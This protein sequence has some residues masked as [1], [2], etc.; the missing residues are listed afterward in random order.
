M[1]FS[2]EPSN[3]KVRSLDLDF[4]ELSWEM[5]DQTVDIWDY[6]FQIFRSESGEG[7]FDPISIA[8]EDRYVFVD[9]FLQIGHKWRVLFYRIRITHKPTGE[10]KDF[11]PYSALPEP[12]LI[13]MEVRRHINLLMQEFGGRRLWVLPLRTFGQRCDCWSHTLSRRTRSGCIKCYDTGFVRGYMAPIEIWGQIDPAPK[14]DQT[15]NVG[16]TQQVNSTGK[17]GY[18]PPLKPRD[19]LVE[20]ENKRWRIVKVGQT[21]KGRAT[22]HQELEVHEIPPRDIE[23]SIPLDL[24]K[25]L[26]ELAITPARNYSN[27]QNLDSF[28]RDVVGNLMELY[29][30]RPR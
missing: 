25:P 4:H 1:P 9:N 3:V 26:R 24:G 30:K 23:Y 20:A 16:A 27:P 11:G 2:I 6:T 19:V 13:A 15:L 5:A 29:A 7:P 21:E 10:W 8:F 22:L 18:Y 12:D 14:T 17:T 28:E